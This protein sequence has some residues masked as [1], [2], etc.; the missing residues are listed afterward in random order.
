MGNNPTFFHL[1]A[2]YN[3]IE[4]GCQQKSEL[5]R[6]FLLFLYFQYIAW[7]SNRAYYML[8][9]SIAKLACGPNRENWLTLPTRSNVKGV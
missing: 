6:G 1:G 9:S 7:S 3:F 2:T 8:N 4:Q 5:F